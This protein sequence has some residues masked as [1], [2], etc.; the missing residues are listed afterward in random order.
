MLNAD[1][2]RHNFGMTVIAVRRDGI[3]TG[4]LM[5]IRMGSLISHYWHRE[6]TRLPN[7]MSVEGLAIVG[8]GQ[9]STQSYEEIS[10]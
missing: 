1:L 8:A 3:F 2:P 10:R 9:L 6:A 7:G 4:Q 5:D